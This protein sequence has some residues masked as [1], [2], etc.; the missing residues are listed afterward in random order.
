[1]LASKLTE[2]KSLETERER[3]LARIS[4]RDRRI[5]ELEA[6]LASA[7][8]VMARAHELEQ[9]LSARDAHLARLE[10]E[11]SEARA[12]AP[13]NDDDLTRIKGI[14][15]KFAAILRELGV[16]RYAQIAAWTDQD[17]Q[18]FAAKLR[19]PPGRIEKSGWIESARAL[20]QPAP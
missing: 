13:S 16:R 4:E 19:V 8:Q 20:A 12:W 1:V 7:A 6:K 3:L 11:L 2:L 18:E 15:P 5:H 10:Q 9:K 17:V 14:G